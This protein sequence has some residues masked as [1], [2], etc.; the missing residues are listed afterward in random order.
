M[1]SPRTKTRTRRASRS[2]GKNKPLTDKELAL[3][4]QLESLAGVD[5]IMDWIP[6]MSPNFH[7]PD[8]LTKLA[9]VLVRAQYEPVY[10]WISVP[11]RHSKTETI[12]HSVPWRLLRDPTCEIAYCTYEANL[13]YSKSRR[14]R[15]IAEQVGV[16]LKKAAKGVQE[17]QTKEGG[18][19]IATGVG[20]PL[21]GRGAKLLII[22]DPLKNREEA[23]SPVIRQKIWDWFTSTALTRVEP[24]GSVIVCHT[25]WHDDDLIGRIKQEFPDWIGIQMPAVE[26]TT[27]KGVSI[28]GEPTEEIKRRALWPSRWP[29]EEL[30]KKRKLVGEY[31]WA[32][33]Y[34]GQPRPKGGRLFGSATRYDVPNIVDL[35][36]PY[37]IVIGAD[38]AATEKTNSDYS[39]IVV[40]AFTGSWDKEDPTNTDN[41][42]FRGD[43]LEVWRGQVSVPEF[44]KR[45]RDMGVK[46]GAPIVVEAVGGFKAVPQMLRQLDKSLK[47]IEAPV[48]GDKFT[49]AL[50]VSAAWNYGRMRVPEQAP[51]LSDF[52][53][54]VEKFT[55]VK[56]AHDDQVDALAHAYNAAQTMMPSVRVLPQIHRPSNLPF[57]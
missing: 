56:D 23:E 34:Q 45:L 44:A 25:R 3:W 41:L 19:V 28:N 48:R 13:A 24:G 9:E 50:P 52:L 49:R 38:P 1:A 12:L 37:K 46:W 43:V 21:T 18:R 22:D 54:E 4:Y 53:S 31:D 29:L 15:E 27:V 14:M 51:W 33:L 2:S 5:S 47:I 8:H 17:W 7:R 11:P 42:G 6:R 35:K 16:K 26:E 10:A 39:A 55:G 36:E 40:C 30:D 57:G 20:G 32:A